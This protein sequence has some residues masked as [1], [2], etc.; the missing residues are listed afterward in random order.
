MWLNRRGRQTQRDDA[1]PTSSFK[2]LCTVRNIIFFKNLVEKD[3]L[4]SIY[5]CEGSSKANTIILKSLLATEDVLKHEGKRAFVQSQQGDSRER[6]CFWRKCFKGRTRHCF[7]LWGTIVQRNLSHEDISPI[8]FLISRRKE[9]H[10]LLSI[11]LIF[12]VTS[13]GQNF[14]HLSWLSLERLLHLHYDGFIKHRDWLYFLYFY[15]CS[16]MSLF[17]WSHHCIFDLGSEAEH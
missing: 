3:H 5:N 6:S 12:I 9:Q 14:R 10:C 11:A 1:G 16:Q 2:M 15:R 17:Y 4:L 13:A 8:S 7:P